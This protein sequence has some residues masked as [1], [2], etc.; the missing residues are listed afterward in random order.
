MSIVR[1]LGIWNNGDTNGVTDPRV[2]PR[3]ISVNGWAMA[4]VRLVTEGKVSG[5]G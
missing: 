5:R 4:S 2:V 3:W 1:V